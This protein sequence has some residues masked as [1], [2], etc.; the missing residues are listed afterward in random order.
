MNES[1]VIE[2]TGTFFF[3]KKEAVNQKLSDNLSVDDVFIVKCN[4]K[5]I[6]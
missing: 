1:Q 2:E 6:V 3:K 4:N 5:K